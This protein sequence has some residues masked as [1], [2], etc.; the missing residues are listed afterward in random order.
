MA[1]TTRD[2]TSYSL[3]DIASYLQD[4]RDRGGPRAIP[5][6]FIHT[7]VSGEIGGASAGVQDLV[8]L[9]VIPAFAEVVG[10]FLT[11]EALGASAGAGVTLRV[12]DSSDDDRYMIATD[13]D[14]AGDVEGLPVPGQRY[15]PVVDTIVKA[16]WSGANPVV[17]KKFSG[18]VYVVPGT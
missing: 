7:V 2:S 18:A 12:G 13:S 17:G 5:I 8:N 11:R 3:L 14:V 9:C 6:P 15:R 10:F 16:K 4:A 1:A